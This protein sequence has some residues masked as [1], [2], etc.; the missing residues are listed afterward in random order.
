MVAI[1]VLL[2]RPFGDSV[3]SGLP[4]D[5]FLLLSLVLLILY[6]FWLFFFFLISPDDSWHGWRAL[7]V[8]TW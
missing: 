6:L 3:V 1:S 2:K 4:L 8:P 5:S 7:L